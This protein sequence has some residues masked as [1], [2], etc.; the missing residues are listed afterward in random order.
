MFNLQ[1]CI[2]R[3][4][5]VQLLMALIHRYTLHYEIQRQICEAWGTKGINQRKKPNSIPGQSSL[6]LYIQLLWV[7]QSETTEGRRM[8]SQSPGKQ[9]FLKMEDKWNGCS[10]IPHKLKKSPQHLG[11]FLLTHPQSRGA[12]NR[13]PWLMK[14][15]TFWLPKITHLVK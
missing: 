2:P 10:K 11:R 1:K 8:I 9:L 15:L 14:M 3:E 12:L 6:C 7:T 4:E 13:V 5:I